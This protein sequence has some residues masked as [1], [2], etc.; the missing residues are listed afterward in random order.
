MD[1]SKQDI[2]I[3]LCDGREL[4][5][6]DIHEFRLKWDSKN[7][8]DYLYFKRKGAIG[9]LVDEARPATIIVTFPMHNVLYY[10]RT[11]ENKED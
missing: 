7:K 10:E 2:S 8:L 4:N 9:G 5:F 3:T 6:Y 11:I 1:E